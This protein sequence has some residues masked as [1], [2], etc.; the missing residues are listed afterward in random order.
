[1]NLQHW[2]VAV[3]INSRLPVKR[4][5]QPYKLMKMKYFTAFAAISLASATTSF[6]ADHLDAPSLSGNGANDI[7]DLF[8]FQ[9][10]ENAANTILVMTVNPFAGSAS[11]YSL[12]SGSTYTFNVDNTGDAM[13]NV[14]YEATFGAANANSQQNYSI[15]RNGLAYATGL[16]GGTFGDGAGIASPTT[17][18]GRSQVG[19]FDDPFFFDLAGFQ[20]GLQFTGD[21]AFAGA[22]VTAVI[23]EIPSTELIS[24]PGNTGIGVWATTSNATGQIDRIGRPAINTVLVSGDENKE[25]FNVA[26]PADD[27]STFGNGVNAVITSLS[28]QGNADAL[29]PILLPDVLTF[30]TD[31][32][33]P[34]LNG[35]GL[36]DDV[37]DG[38]LTLLTASDTPVGDGVDANDGTSLNV[39]PFLAA[40]NTVPEPSSAL[41]L[42]LGLLAGVSRRARR[43]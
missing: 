29:T 9:S 11:G 23:I 39:F 16:T 10:L 25:A 21:D 35:R 38:A 8:A 1:M 4:R 14:V 22:D 17:G 32:T 30:D 15:T 40:S 13:A 7:N 6:A 31:S 5:Q 20:N 19:T 18:G 33:A 3:L 42:G 41:L 28:N 43:A 36:N 37:I 27:F 26:S 2:F 24:A 34:F 12:D